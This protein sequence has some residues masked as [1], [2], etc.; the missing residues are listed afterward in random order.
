LKKE[1]LVLQISIVQD[2]TP[3]VTLAL[4]EESV[5]KANSDERS[6]RFGRDLDYLINSDASRISISFKEYVSSGLRVGDRVSVEVTK[7]KQTSPESVAK[8]LE[9]TRR[10]EAY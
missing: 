10:T 6:R 9:S 8:L 4:L 5:L 2:A 3:S 7:V 1:Y